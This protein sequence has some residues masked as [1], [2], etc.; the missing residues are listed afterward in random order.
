[1]TFV[2]SQVL[3]IPFLLG[4]TALFTQHYLPSPPTVWMLV[5]NA[6]VLGLAAGIFEEVA[7][8]VAYRYFLTTTRTWRE[9]LMF[10]TGHGGMEAILLGVV[11]L[12][13]FAAMYTL[14]TT[15]SLIPDAQRATIEA[16]LQA[17][18]SQPTLTVF[19][20]AYERVLALCTHLAMALLVLQVFT[21]GNILYLFAA[22]LWHAAVDGLAVYAVATWGAYA[23]EAL[24]S[25]FALAAL[26]LIFFYRP[27]TPACIQPTTS[28]AS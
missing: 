24:L 22:I 13:T 26:A 3:H 6:M 1:V 23:T 27:R 9:A 19:L 8:W 17:Y 4:L 5:F 15:P 12:V 18:W 11:V 7:R 21:R 16:Q 2:A 14:Q 25:L 28:L 20:G 10:G